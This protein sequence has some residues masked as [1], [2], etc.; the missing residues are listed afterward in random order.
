MSLRVWLDVAVVNPFMEIE[1]DK[2]FNR[3]ITYYQS[4]IAQTVD[5]VKDRVKIRNFF[6]KKYF[7]R[8]P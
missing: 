3:R 7:P 5:Y 2:S 6:P 8:W 1:N 4:I